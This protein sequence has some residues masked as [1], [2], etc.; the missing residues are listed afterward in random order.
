MTGLTDACMEDLLAALRATKTLRTLEMRN[1]TLTDDSA[2][3][4]VQAA[5][6]CQSMEEM[7]YAPLQLIINR[8]EVWKKPRESSS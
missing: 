2:A 4:L 8:L 6:Q 3:G 1:N 5:Q 7:R